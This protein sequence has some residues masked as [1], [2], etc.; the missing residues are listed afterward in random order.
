MVGPEGLEVDEL[1]AILVH[2]QPE[3][4]LL[5]LALVSAAG[6]VQKYMHVSNQ[7]LLSSPKG[8]LVLKTLEV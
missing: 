3:G 6:R 7:T 8:V 1:A 4:V 2:G 5:Q